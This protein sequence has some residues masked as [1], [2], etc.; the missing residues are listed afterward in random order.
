VSQRGAARLLFRTQRP[1]LVAG[2]HSKSVRTFCSGLGCGLNSHFTTR[3]DSELNSRL[4]RYVAN[5]LKP[6]VTRHLQ[7]QFD[8]LLAP[9]LSRKLRRNLAQDLKSKVKG[10]VTLLLTSRSKPEATRTSQSFRAITVRPS[11]AT[12]SPAQWPGRQSK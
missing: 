12:R 1:P 10:E 6:I 5:R 2:L 4:S 11:A 3:L 7:R 9:I 8:S